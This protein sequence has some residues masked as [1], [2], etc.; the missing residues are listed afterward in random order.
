MA[1]ISPRHIHRVIYYI[2][3]KLH[4]NIRTTSWTIGLLQTFQLINICNIIY[5]PILLDEITN[6]DI[7]RRVTYT[8]HKSDDEP[9]SLRKRP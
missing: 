2:K 1:S 6:R 5:P 9:E 8:T 4:S 3:K 7:L